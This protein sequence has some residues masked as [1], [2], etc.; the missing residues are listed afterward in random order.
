MDGFD[1][2][3]VMVRPRRCSRDSLQACGFIPSFIH[4]PTHPPTYLHQQEI[5]PSFDWE[6]MNA[7]VAQSG[8]IP[9]ADGRWVGGFGSMLYKPSVGW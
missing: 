5:D 2:L 3:F 8:A 9:G 7:M 4:P 1:N 6:E